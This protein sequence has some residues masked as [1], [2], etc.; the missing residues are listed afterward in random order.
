MCKSKRWN[1]EHTFLD[2]ESKR[3]VVDVVRVLHRIH[4]SQ[5][6]ITNAWRT[7]RVGRDPYSPKV[8]LVRDRT[9]LSDAIG[10]DLAPRAIMSGRSADLDDARPFTE[11][12][13]DGPNAFID[14]VSGAYPEPRRVDPEPRPS[15]TSD[16]HAGRH[17]P[18]P[19]PDAVIDG[20]FDH[21]RRLGTEI[22]HRCESAFEKRVRF[23]G[24]PQSPVFDRTAGPWHLVAG[25]SPPEMN[26]CINETW[27]YGAGS[28]IYGSIE[29]AGRDL[30]FWPSGGNPVAVDNN[31]RIVDGV[32]A[33]SVKK[34]ARPDR[35]ARGPVRISRDWPIVSR[36]ANPHASHRSRPRT[37][38]NCRRRARL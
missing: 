5:H 30:G 20:P 13:V 16:R 24:R 35:N 10:R 34:T 2:D 1:D 37:A 27:H 29:I 3:F 9:D 14:T 15:G 6:G 19:W 26:V 28:Q 12:G 7:H 36:Q 25:A 22:S 38:S 31:Y 23:G 4:S 11:T 17:H 8:G 21:N 32:G 18:R 33:S